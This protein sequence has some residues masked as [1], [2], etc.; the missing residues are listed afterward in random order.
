MAPATGG[1]EEAV[2]RLMRLVRELMSV[3][4]PWGI[5]RQNSGA[6]YAAGIPPDE[7]GLP[8]VGAVQHAGQKNEGCVPDG[9]CECT[10]RV[11]RPNLQGRIKMPMLNG[12]Q[13]HALRRKLLKPCKRD[14]RAP[15]RDLDPIKQG[16]FQYSERAILSEWPDTVIPFLPK[17]PA[18][19]LEN[20][21]TRL[22]Q[23]NARRRAQGFGK[24]VCVAARARS[25][26][27]NA[28]PRVQIEGLNHVATRRGC[29]VDIV[30]R[31]PSMSFTQERSESMIDWVCQ[32][33]PP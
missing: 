32:S 29:E 5:G 1:D 13:Q 12:R 22:N 18:G 28:H 10:A 4:D 24:Q 33:G 26:L 3:I 25:D 2:D 7:E 31:S 17:R 27:E 16:A 11:R 6:G 23:A 19:E 15:R 20:L 9:A 14:V 8:R 30:G 21:Q